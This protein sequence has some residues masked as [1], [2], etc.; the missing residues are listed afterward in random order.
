MS[1]KDCQMP[2]RNEFKCAVAGCIVFLL[3]ILSSAVEKREKDSFAFLT[4][5]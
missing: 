2:Q 4:L 1:L 3:S 5:D